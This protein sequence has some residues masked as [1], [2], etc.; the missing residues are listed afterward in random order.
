[1]SRRRGKWSKKLLRAA[2]RATGLEHRFADYR[3]RVDRIGAVD[4]QNQ[5]LLML[6]WRA[7][8]SKHSPQPTHMAGSIQALG[9]PLFWSS[10]SDLAMAVQPM[11]KQS[12]QPLQSSATTV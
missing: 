5:L 11:R 8:T 4:R 3:K 6:A 12:V 10:S 2:L 9:R 7:Q 1:M